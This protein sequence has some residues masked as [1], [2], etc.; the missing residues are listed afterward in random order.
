MMLPSPVRLALLLGQKR[1]A[2]GMNHHRAAD[3]ARM[4]QFGQGQASCALTWSEI[5]QCMDPALDA[6][7]TAWIRQM[8]PVERRDLHDAEAIRAV[9]E[10]IRDV[11]RA[12]LSAGG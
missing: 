6:H 7:H 3:L 9:L 5:A 4:R 12:A 2:E 11:G 10:G 8:L 1:C